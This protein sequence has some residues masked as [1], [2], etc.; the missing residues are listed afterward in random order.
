MTT[1]PATVRTD[2][3]ATTVT[4]RPPSTWRTSLSRTGLELREM[5]RSRDDVVFTLALPVLLL[6]IFGSVFTDDIAPGVTFTQYFTAGMAASGVLLT[7]FQ[8][9]AIAIAVE[10]D[11]GALR[12]LE[13][14]PMPRAAFFLGKVGLVL[15]TGTAQLAV[16]LAVAWLVFDVPMPTGVSGWATLVWVAVLGSAAGTLLGIAYSSV[17][18]SARSATAVVAPVVLVLQF[19]SGVFFVFTE[20]PGWMQAVAS[21]FPLRWMTQGF[22]AALL[23]ETM[24]A[25]EAGGSW[26]LGLVALVLAG[27]VVVGLVLCLTTFRW[28]RRGDR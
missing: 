24:E 17:P 4:R 18:S 10:R 2:R 12:R 5:L 13:G 20:L 15:V 9:L 26:D 16:L 14:T 7:S 27:W 1:T 21:A 19:V 11:T 28:R 25:A 8:S 23:P 22:R 6:V 3:R